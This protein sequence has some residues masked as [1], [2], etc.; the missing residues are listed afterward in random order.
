LKALQAIAADLL[1]LAA[2]DL[3]AQVRTDAL[4]EICHE[5]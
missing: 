2:K 1:K 4:Q 3:D 5:S